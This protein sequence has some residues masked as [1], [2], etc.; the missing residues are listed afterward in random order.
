MTVN[1]FTPNQSDVEQS[2]AGFYVGGAQ[3]TGQGPFTGGNVT[4]QTDT[5]HVEIGLRALKVA[6]DGTGGFQAIEVRVPVVSQFVA[7]STYTLSSYI[8]STAGGENLRYYCQADTGSIGTVG[9][10]T[11][12]AGW[13]RYSF[14]F[15]LPNLIAQQYYA[16]RFDTGGTAQAIT[17]WWD[18]LQFEQGSSA[19]PWTL[20]SGG[21]GLAASFTG[22]VQKLSVSFLAATSKLTATFARSPSMAQPNASIT[23]SATAKDANGNLLPNLS[24]V[25]VTV[26]FPDGS[27]SAFSLGSGVTNA[28]GGVYTL[29]YKTKTQGECVEDWL[30]TAADGVTTAEYHNIT[31]VSF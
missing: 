4:I 5:A 27:T 24:A 12:A 22:A 1:L 8:Y 18:A 16:L 21:V 13:N 25:A 11:L 28:G 7:G 26:T 29:A 19:S 30:F 3:G 10:I 17:V 6:T 15:T 31:P 2:I 9:N 14:T 20:G 23:V